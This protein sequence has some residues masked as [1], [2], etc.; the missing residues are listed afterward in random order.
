M[1]QQVAEN[2][3]TGRSD[4]PKALRKLKDRVGRDIFEATR[5]YSLW[6][7]MGNETQTIEKGVRL[8]VRAMAPL[9]MGERNAALK[10]LVQT[11]RNVAPRW[12]ARRGLQLRLEET[13][14]WAPECWKGGPILAY[15]LAS[16]APGEVPPIL[17]PESGLS[18]WTVAHEMAKS[19]Y[20][21]FKLAAV[22]GLADASGTK[23]LD[24]VD[25]DSPC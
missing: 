16:E 5:N 24:L 1:L 18:R 9:A 12:F 13:D 3:F 4:G 2:I 17:W 10:N 15:V 14:P 20:S 19:G 11:L 6:A 21:D 7:A 23:V 8:T 25:T 22:L